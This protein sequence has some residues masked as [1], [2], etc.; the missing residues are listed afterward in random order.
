MR[1]YTIITLIPILLLSFSL[2]FITRALPPIW[3]DDG[4]LGTGD[5]SGSGTGSNAGGQAVTHF[6]RSKM[7]VVI[8]VEQKMWLMDLISSSTTNIK[9]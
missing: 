1:K 2:P 6:A 7:N 3:V 4:G 9:S 8:L 5:G